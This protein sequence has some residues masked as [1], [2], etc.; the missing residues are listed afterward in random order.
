M[1]RVAHPRST[2]PFTCSRVRWLNDTATHSRTHP[3]I[4][5]L[6]TRFGEILDIP[7]CHR[8]PPRAGDGRDLTV[9][10]RDRTTSGTAGRG[11][12]C[13]GARRMAVE[14]KNP[15]SKQN[16]KRSVR[17][18]CKTPAAR[19]FRQNGNPGANLRFS[20]CRY[21]QLSRWQPIHP[22]KNHGIRRGTHQFRY[23]I[24]IK[25][26]H[27]SRINRRPAARASVRAAA[28]PTLHSRTV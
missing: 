21:E 3:W 24:R 11:N 16:P 25:Q 19:A 7:G 20:D 27:D 5:Y 6:N 1:V 12:T 17:G 8:H 4:D 14:W 2:L 15:I 13:I 26:D 10:L 28:I 23:H 22:G 18:M 9:R